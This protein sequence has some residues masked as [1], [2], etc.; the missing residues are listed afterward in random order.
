MSSFDGQRSSF[1]ARFRSKKDQG[2]SLGS[3]AGSGSSNKA[4]DKRK[5]GFNPESSKLSDG[6]NS[7][8][9]SEAGSLAAHSASPLDSPA[10]DNEALQ[11]Q[12]ATSSAHLTS[13]GP[14]SVLEKR[15][16]QTHPHVADASPDRDRQQQPKAKDFHKTL[17]SRTSLR[18]C[19]DDPSELFLGNFTDG[20]KKSSMFLWDDRRPAALHKF[21]AFLAAELG[22]EQL[23]FW[24]NAQQHA[25]DLERLLQLSKRIYNL[26]LP[27]TAPLALN[28]TNEERSDMQGIYQH[29]MT[30][31]DPFKP[32]QDRA[33]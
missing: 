25:D 17:L 5:S 6:V 14:E 26:H 10:L 32:A 12:Q 27:E 2:T 9:P 22:A 28:I 29:W 7:K 23:V 18:K 4:N 15:S 33:L 30:I 3:T 19:L 11:N 13:A 24:L 31:R 1:F 16:S 8:T 20:S 21:G